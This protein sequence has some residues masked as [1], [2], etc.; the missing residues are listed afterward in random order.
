MRT[1][2]LDIGTRR[3]GIAYCDDATGIPLPLTTVHHTSQEEL[4]AQVLAIV[5]ARSIDQCIIGLPLLP[6]GAEGAQAEVVRRAGIE[7]EKKGLPCRYMDERYTTSQYR[8]NVAISAN[9]DPDAAAA[10]AI[11]SAAIGC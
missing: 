6:S 8:Q 2:A 11:L 9:S 10:C 4:V 3:T 7:L 1:L 5:T